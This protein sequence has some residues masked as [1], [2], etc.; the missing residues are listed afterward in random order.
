[1]KLAYETQ[2]QKSGEMRNVGSGSLRFDRGLLAHDIEN[3]ADAGQQ[4]RVG[5]EL[6]RDGDAKSRWHDFQ[7]GSKAQFDTVNA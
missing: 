4:Q 7:N 1:M 2:Q 5:S 6:Y 3:G